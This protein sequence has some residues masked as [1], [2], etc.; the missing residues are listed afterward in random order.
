MYPTAPD[1][2]KYAGDHDHH[3]PAGH[4]PAPG[5]SPHGVARVYAPPYIVSTA[6]SSRHVGGAWSS[7]LCHCC[8]DP[9]NC[10]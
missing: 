9:A 7:G 4:V 2:E 5:L 8:D 10:K 6:R 3:I 1:H